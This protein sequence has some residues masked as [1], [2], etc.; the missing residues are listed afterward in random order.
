[1]NPTYVN[2][3]KLI[4]HF[5]LSNKE[6][7][8]ERERESSQPL[9]NPI[10][11]DLPNIKSREL[12][13]KLKAL[14]PVIE[15]TSIKTPLTSEYQYKLGEVL[16]ID[17][18]NTTTKKVINLCI[19]NIIE[20]NKVPPFLLYLLH[21]NHENNTMYFPNFKTE[22][23][24]IDEASKNINEIFKDWSS[25][26]VYK[27][28]LETKHNIYLF[29]EVK[30]EYIL[31]K[32]D[33]HDVWWW[34]SIFEI[35][36][37][38]KIL[39]FTIDRS[40]YSVFYK[41]P[42]LISLFR[43]QNRLSTPY[44]GYMGGYYTYI[45]FAAAFGVPK[46]LPIS[47][48]GPYY[49]FNDYHGA[50]R[51][52]IWSYNRKQMIVNNEDITLNGFGVFKKGGI[53]RYAIFGEKIRYFL[54]RESDPEDDSKISQELAKE[55]SFY[56]ETLKVRDVSAKWADNHDMAYI[57]SFLLDD[58][59]N[60]SRRYTINFVVRDFEQQVPLTYHY[61]DTTEI[62]KIDSEIQKDMPFNYEDYNIA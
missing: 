17:R 46:Q 29:Y 10:T 50:G 39:N 2:R 62:A 26:P 24:V 5:Q 3:K 1:M 13:I 53:A 43:N 54:N 23:K 51:W 36:N 40:V 6:R 32:I 58:K 37:T 15:D 59:N 34:T 14:L 18:V 47:S 25:K 33:Y 45:A 35:V 57:G 56:K 22:N 60:A 30:Y 44:I 49:Y 9:D 4:K 42:M 16:D 48:L 12:S 38:Q 27:G 31:E 55:K 28:F 19:F 41:K 20:G 8:S 21:K 52:A 61:V 11:L 7:E